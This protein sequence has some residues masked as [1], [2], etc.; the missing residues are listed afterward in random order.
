MG[1]FIN[2]EDREE[3]VSSAFDGTG[4]GGGEKTANGRLNLIAEAIL[5]ITCGFSTGHTIK[6]IC[7]ELE[8]LSKAGQPL[9]KAK[10]WAYCRLPRSVFLAQK[11]APQ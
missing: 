1:S 2:L 8:L 10:Q 4:F 11:E 7:L 6:M 5:K 3:A 9:I